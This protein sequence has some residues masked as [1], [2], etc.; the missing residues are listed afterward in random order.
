MVNGYNHMK[1]DMDGP[2]APEKHQ[3][4]TVQRFWA[5]LGRQPPPPTA[6][7]TN[8]CHWIGE[9]IAAGLAQPG[10]LTACWITGQAR[11][12]DLAAKQDGGAWLSAE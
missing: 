7:T 9:I 2:I 12:A 1:V 5:R 8:N 3:E 11:K 10:L 4:M 6:M